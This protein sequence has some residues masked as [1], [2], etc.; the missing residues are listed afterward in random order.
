MYLLQQIKTNK[1]TF[2][3][4]GGLSSAFVLFLFMY[5]LILPGDLDINALKDRQ[6][7]DFIRMKKDDTL[8]ERDRRLPDKPPPPKRPPPPELETPDVQA[9][10]TPKL[11]IKFPDIKMP[12]DTDGAFVG[13][14]K[15]L[16]DGG[17]VPLVRIT[18]RYPRNALLK[19]QEG[20]VVIE[21]LVDEGGSVVT[22]KIVNANPPGVFNAAAIQAV[23]K[24]KF[25]PRVL[26]GIA[27]QQ[28]G[29]TTIEFII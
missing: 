11:D 2:F 19:N 5:L 20:V 24:W 4:A 3:I 14:G 12:I 7:V 6:M 1:N 25:K 27:I 29:L 21:L 16:G 10:P 17:L 23:L 13:G 26:N 22:A 9:L 15:Y 28:R 18:P 8:N